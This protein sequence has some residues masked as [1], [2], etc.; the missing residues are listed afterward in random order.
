M[1]TGDISSSNHGIIKIILLIALLLS[2]G[3]F[4]GQLIAG[5]ISDDHSSDDVVTIPDTDG[6]GWNDEEEL[7]A[8]TDPENP[9]TDGDGIIDPEDNN[10][11]VPL[12]TTPPTTTS[13]P[14]TLPPTTTSPPTTTPAP[15]QGTTIEV[16][17]FHATHQCTSCKLLGEYAYYTIITYYGD[18]YE[19]GKITFSSC[20]YEDDENSELVEW[21]NVYGSSIFVIVRWDDGQTEVFNPTNMLWTYISNKSAFAV[22]FKDYLKEKLCL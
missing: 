2:S 7:L 1:G 19:E 9:D 14:T 11:L 3:L 21:L 10:A 17:H 12:S 20:D 18:E 22:H 6:D 16:Y 4:L 15:E 8:G 5:P 13:A